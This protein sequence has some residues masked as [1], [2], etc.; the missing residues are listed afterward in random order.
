[1]HLCSAACTKIH[2]LGSRQPHSSPACP[3]LITQEAVQRWASYNHTQQRALFESALVVVHQ[4]AWQELE[5]RM[6]V[7]LQRLP[8]LAEQA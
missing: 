7:A 5:G 4:G 3:H 1:M 6:Q 8:R 2:Q